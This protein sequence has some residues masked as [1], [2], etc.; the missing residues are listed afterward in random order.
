ML[1]MLIINIV[2]TIFGGLFQLL[3]LVFCGPFF[4]LKAF[5]DDM[6]LIFGQIDRVSDGKAANKNAQTKKLIATAIKFQSRMIE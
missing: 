4:Y 1:N 6:K 2:M 3:L 5:S